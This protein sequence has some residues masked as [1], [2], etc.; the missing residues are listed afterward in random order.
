MTIVGTGQTYTTAQAG[1]YEAAVTNTYGCTGRDT[2]QL[3]T[4]PKPAVTNS[5]LSKT[6]CSGESTNIALTSDQ[7]GTNF[8]WT[9][10][11]TSGNITGFSADSG[12]IIN[13]VLTN[14]GALAGIVTY[15]VTPKLG[16]C[17]GDMVNFPVTVNPGDSVKVTISASDNNVCSGTS[18]TFQAFPTNGGSSPSYQWKVNGINA[19]PNNSSYTYNP[20]SG[21][22]VSCV[23]TSS[24]TACITNNPA[25]S[26]QVNMV[27]ISNSVVGVSIAASANPVCA[28]IPVIF[29]ATP[30]NGGSA[31]SYQ[32][33]V[34][35]ISVGT[36]SPSYTY[37]PAS[38]DLVSC[39]LTSNILCP[40]G[41]PATSNTITMTVNPNLPVSV[42]ISASANPFCQGSAVTFTATPTNGGT[43]PYYQW[44]VN[45]F[46]VGPHNAGLIPIL[47]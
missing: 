13:Q 6:I 40:S 9:A 17:A 16:G 7:P 3:I 38:G 2:V 31:P 42:S 29:T 44:I 37:N 34:N 26:N 8:H 25:T 15:Q 21:D 5:P 45:G 19:G 11:L 20:A 22:L 35:G 10:T 41:N 27:I 46:N 47:R 4:N 28:G 24:L 14:N 32:W 43:S 33:K 1:T 39:I 36:N 12:L 18:V 23:L 30:T